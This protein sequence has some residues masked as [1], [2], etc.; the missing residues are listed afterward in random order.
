[1]LGLS[2]FAGFA[3]YRM[4]YLLYFV[5]KRITRG[6]TMATIRR[7]FRIKKPILREIDSTRKDRPANAL[8]NEPLGEAIKMRRCPGIV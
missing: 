3:A 7:S 5:I 6:D 2:E 1:V 4:R 8:A